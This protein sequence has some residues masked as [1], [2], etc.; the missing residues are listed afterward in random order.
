MPGIL[1]LNGPNLGQ[2]GQREPGLYGTQT[3]EDILAMLRAAF[4]AVAFAHVQ[5]DLEGVLIERLHAAKGRSTGVIIN[6][7]GYAHTSVALRDAIASCGV[8]VVEVH[9]T[10]VHAREPFRHVL[11][12]GAVCAGVITGL[13]PDGYRLAADHLLR[14]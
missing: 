11:L 1:V 7:G 10:N 9:L 5:S 12:T 4:P 3:L 14:R 2:L 8:P 13:G 6:P